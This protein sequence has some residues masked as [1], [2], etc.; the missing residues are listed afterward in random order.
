MFDR[1][2]VADVLNALRPMESFFG[3]SSAFSGT[4]SDGSEWS[5]TPA[6]EVASTDDQLNLRVV[7][8]GVS[9]KDVKVM[10]QGNQLLI[11]GERK[12]PENL[13]SSGGY[14]YLSYGKFF[15][16]IDLPDRLDLD[17]MSCRLHDG[18]LDIEIPVKAEMKPRQIPV[19]GSGSRKAFAA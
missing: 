14:S 1:M 9:E 7:L 13:S 17:K 6:F 19:I 5:F 10:V 18:V 3:A 4:I 15:R 2:L 8:P 12:S 16:A 11:E